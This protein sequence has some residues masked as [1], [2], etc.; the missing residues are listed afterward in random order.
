MSL[1]RDVKSCTSLQLCGGIF[2]VLRVKDLFGGV[3]Q[4]SKVPIA[5]SLPARSTLPN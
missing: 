4:A 3:Y 2:C 5:F 1:C